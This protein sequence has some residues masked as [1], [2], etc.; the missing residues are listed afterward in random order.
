MNQK[1]AAFLFAIGVGSAATVSAFQQNMDQCAQDCLRLHRACLATGV[2]TD[3]CREELSA[4]RDRC[5]I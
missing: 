5:G 1:V 2:G 4:C 3:Q